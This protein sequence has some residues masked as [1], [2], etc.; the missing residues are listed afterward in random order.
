MLKRSSH[1]SRQIEAAARLQEVREELNLEDD[2]PI[3]KEFL[4]FE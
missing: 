1:V 4:N 3:P 2:E